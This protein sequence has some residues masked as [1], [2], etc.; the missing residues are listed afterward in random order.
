[1]SWLLH[2]GG[3]VDDEA[4]ER[5]ILE[6]AKEFVRKVG[7]DGSGSFTG[8]HTGTHQLP[9]P[10]AST[11]DEPVPPTPPGDE[12]PGLGGGGGKAP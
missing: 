6:A 9:D 11:L 1:M 5:E 8:T 2:V 3:H 12:G 4:R 7:K 10:G